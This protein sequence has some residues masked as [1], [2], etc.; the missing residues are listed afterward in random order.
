MTDLPPDGSGQPEYLEQG[1]GGPWGPSSREP[2]S[3]RTPVLIGLAVA[4]LAAVG[5]GA[6]AAVSFFATG[7]QPAE[8]LPGSTLAYASVDLD[9]SGG[10][11]IE[12]LRMLKKFPAIADEIDLDTDDD[13]TKQ[14]IE[15]SGLLCD[16]VSYSVD[17]EPWLGDRA[18]VAAVDLGEDEP[19]VAVVVQVADADA[20]GAGLSALRACT[21][22]DDSPG[23]EINGDWAVI[24]E[25]QAE[26]EAVV[27]AT[28]DGT[29]ADDEDYQHWTD[30]VGDAG[31]VSLYAAPAAGAYLADSAD[32]LF[33]L[34]MM[35]DSASSS[36]GSCVGT[37]DGEVVCNDTDTEAAPAEGAAGLPDDLR[38]KLEDFA[39]MA[40]TVRFDDGGLEL[41]VAGDAT[42]SGDVLSDSDAGD[43]VLATL[44]DDTA[45]AFGVGF[46]H[47]WAADLLDSM[48]ASSG[49]S[50]D[51]LVAEA[52]TETGLSLPD[53]LETLL[54]DSAVLAVGDDVDPEAYFNGD[55]SDLP[56]G[57]KIRGDAHEIEAV[58]EKLRAQLPPD[59]DLVTDS[60][61][62]YVVVG[63]DEDYAASLLEDG[64]LGD[65]DA[66]G[67]VADDA[68]DAAAVLFVN[69]DAGDWLDRLAGD[70]PEAAD[71]LEPLQ[72][73]GLT[74]RR[75]GDVAHAVL[76]LTT[77]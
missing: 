74:V 12:A 1:S 20:A 29:L 56:V 62:D 72:A 39:G 54:G 51:E 15:D 13:L 22:D 75:D 9:P 8:A 34:G 36:S 46:T 77:D 41:E 14:L 60:E 2:R 17:V 30:E 40:L 26:A 45:V 7:P 66:F 47:G 24:A 58:L 35:G 57:A 28:D 73:L 63:V 31:V 16:D 23:W 52:E 6:W 70:D 71:N 44:P 61:G 32:S 50:V 53:D 27:A 10:Q 11:K 4:G 67:S 76:R 64:G 25:T 55:G 65:T 49:L 43:D 59:V 68:E 42:L 21:E 69:F 18:A 37:A 38:Q 48:A 5:V 3:R 33:G 19:V